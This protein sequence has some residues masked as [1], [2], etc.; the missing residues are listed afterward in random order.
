MPHAGARQKLRD[1]TAQRTAAEHEDGRCPESL[2]P[3]PAEA[4][5]A[6]LAAVTFEAL[7]HRRHSSTPG[8]RSRIVRPTAPSMKLS[9]HGPGLWWLCLIRGVQA[10]D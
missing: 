9:C 6:H 3:F 7:A 5:Q 2:L 8:A 4:R 10:L 1:D